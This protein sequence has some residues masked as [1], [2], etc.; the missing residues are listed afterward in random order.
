MTHLHTT[1]HMARQDWEHQ[2]V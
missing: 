2:H 1:S